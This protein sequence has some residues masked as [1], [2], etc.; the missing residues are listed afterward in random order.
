MPNTFYFYSDCT[1]RFYIVYASSIMT[2]EQRTVRW[3][4]KFLRQINFPFSG[5]VKIWF[6]QALTD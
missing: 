1:N 3:F 6:S 4:E 2:P 5:I